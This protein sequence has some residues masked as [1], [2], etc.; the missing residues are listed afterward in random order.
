M[1]W[2]QNQFG[3]N[4]SPTLISWVSKKNTGCSCFGIPIVEGVQVTFSLEFF[5]QIKGQY[6]IVKKSWHMEKKCFF[7]KCKRLPIVPRW[8]K[9]LIPIQFLFNV[10]YFVRSFSIFSC[11]VVHSECSPLSSQHFHYTLPI[12]L[13]KLYCVLFCHPCSSSPQLK[14]ITWK[15]ETL[16]YKHASPCKTPSNLAESFFGPYIPPKPNQLPFFFSYFFM[17]KKNLSLGKT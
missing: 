17:Q 16:G 2:K 13:V 3:F 6:K 8:E 5:W 15:R 14:L 9:K 11:W 4:L 10:K 7:Q 1:S 12:P